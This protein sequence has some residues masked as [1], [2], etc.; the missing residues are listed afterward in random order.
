MWQKAGCLDAK[1]PKIDLPVL[2]VGNFTVG[3]GGKTPT[4]LALAKHAHGDGAEARHPDARLW[5]QRRKGPHL[6][7]ETRDSADHVGDEPLLMAFTAPV[8]VSRNRLT[9]QSF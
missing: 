8:A 1:P 9:A 2:C 7:D 6:V 4:V 3:G 5:R